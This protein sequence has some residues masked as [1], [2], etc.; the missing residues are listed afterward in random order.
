MSS[1]ETI[2]C[3]I[4]VN[5]NTKRIFDHVCERIGITPSAAYNIFTNA[6]ASEQRIPFE[7][8]ANPINP[9]PQPKTALDE[10][11]EDLAKRGLLRDYT[12]EEINT[13]IDKTLKTPLTKEDKEFINEL[14]K[15]KK[16]HRK[17]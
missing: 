14:L 2:T 6:V 3:S 5:A 1:S 17:S 4:R 7:V 8:K 15:N 10:M 11:R 9:D 16:C 13:M 12:L